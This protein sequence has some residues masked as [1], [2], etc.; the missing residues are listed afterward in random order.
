MCVCVEVGA[1]VTSG[2]IEGG[3]GMTRWFDCW[4]VL[5]IEFVM[6]SNCFRN[7]STNGVDIP[8]APECPRPPN[9]TPPAVCLT[10]LFVVNESA[11]MFIYLVGVLRCVLD[12]LVVHLSV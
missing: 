6:L 5:Q 2:S 7:A 8:I 1:T 9:P 10:K 4:N 11:L 3:G 12:F